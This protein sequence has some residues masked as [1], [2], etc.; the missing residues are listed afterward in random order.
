MKKPSIRKPRTFDL[1]T[2]ASSQKTLQ[3]NSEKTAKKP[4]RKKRKPRAFSTSIEMRSTDDSAAQRIDIDELPDQFAEQLTP[5]VPQNSSQH[6]GWSKLF[7][8]TLAALISLAAGLWFDQLI[9]DLFARQ[10]W[11]GWLAVGLTG[12]LIFAGVAIIIRE[13][14]GF[15]RMAKVSH[16]RAQGD[17]ATNENELN[18]AKMTVVSLDAL[19]ANRPETAHGRAVLMQH[20]DEVLD[21]RDLIHL[22]ERDLLRPLDQKA[23]TLVM[24]SARR[25]S[26]VTAVSPRALVD[27][28]FVLVENIRLI[29]QIADL[30]GGRPGTFGFWRLARNVLAHLAVTGAIAVGDGLLQQIIG[31]GVAAKISSRLGEGIVNGLLTA[32]IGIAAIDVCRPLSFSDQTRPGIKDFMGELLKSPPGNGDK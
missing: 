24:G 6:F 23:K 25:V 30:Y 13:F 27:I 19:Y 18:L 3:S 29:R 14:L 31:H 28:G 26:I 7:F 9:R 8:G 1:D 15:A 10:D 11:L 12:L 4:A 22:A 16:L 32:R 21:G 17:R 2:E 5:P 20:T